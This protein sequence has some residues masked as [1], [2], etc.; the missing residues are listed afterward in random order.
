MTARELPD[1]AAA[2][3]W[4]APDAPVRLQILG[5]LRVWREGVELAPGSRQQSAVLALLLAREG[6]PV[7]TDE[8]IGLLWGEDA[9]ASA[10]NVIHQYIGSL[11]RLLEPGLRARQT[12]S[13]LLRRGNGY[14]CA[15]GP[16]A[17]DLAMF[18]A[19]MSRAQAFVERGEDTA[20]L[21]HLVDAL[22]LWS[23]PAGDG[24]DPGATA[25]ATFAALN[26]SFFEAVVTAT[27]IAVGVGRPEVV[28]PSLRLAAA[29][30]PF[31]EPVQAGLVTAL[32]AAG[33]QAEALEVFRTVRA[34]LGA[35][36]GIEPGHLLD[37]AQRRVLTQN[38]PAPALRVV[39][40]PA[41]PGSGERGALVV[42][43]AEE[44]AL[45]RAAIA[46]THA[47]E[48]AAV[49][50]EGEPGAGKTCLLDEV[51][52][53]AAARGALV[54]WG[55][56]L[57]GDGTPSL[58]PWTQVAG[59]AL[60]RLP[61]PDR[62]HWLSGELSI[63]LTPP[64]ETAAGQITPDTTAQ[65][66]LFE[67]VVGLLESL[68]AQQP[69][70]LV[71][72]DLQW[73][74][75]ASL[76]L[77]AHV[78]A[79]APRGVVLLTALRERASTAN[80]EL[81]KT[82][83]A[84]GR[85]PGHRRL[86]LGPLAFDDVAELLRRETGRQPSAG[87]TRS[88]LA[89]TDGNPFFV[90][91]LSRVLPA[92]GS[93][94]DAAV[95]TTI[96]DLVLTLVSALDDATAR[97]VHIAA[98]VGRQIDL[99]LLARAAGLEVQTCLDQLDAAAVQGLI[100]LS[101]DDPF[102]VRF[103]H[104]VVREAVSTAITAER[105]LDLHRRIADALD[106]DG[107]PEDPV[108][109]QFAHHLWSAGPLVDPAR[110]IDALIRA[111]RCAAAKTAL[112]T[113]E[114]YLRSAVQTARA[115][116]DSGLEFDALSELITVLGMS[117]PHDIAVM[118]FQERA[119][120]LARSAGRDEDAAVLL[121]SRWMALAYAA[122]YDR[123][124][125]LA[126]RLLTQGEASS[127]PVVR[128]LG[129]QAWGL[130]QVSVG[131]IGEAYRHLSAA[132]T[133]LVIVPAQR[134]GDVVWYA[135][136]LSALGLL[137]ETTALH[138]D[139]GQA[140]TLLRELEVLAGDDPFKITV[141]AVHSVRIASVAGDADWALRATEKGLAADPELS[142][143]FF[144]MYQRLARHWALAVTGRDPSGSA[145]EVRRLITENLLDPPR[146]DIATWYGLLAEMHLAAGELEH[147]MNALEL[148]D[149]ALD[150]YGQRYSEGLILLMRARLLAAQGRP[151]ATVTAAAEAAR[152][153]SI[154]REAHL[155]ARR[156]EDFLAHQR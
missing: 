113:A 131:N 139:V 101:S 71:L 104:D 99:R 102:S 19:R 122:Q 86:T 64:G 105:T 69:V 7:S 132:S 123:S 89:R 17:L 96:R 151:S 57:D 58:W 36:L 30:A 135:Q 109:E 16:D 121:Y 137:A 85:V 94:D 140:Q 145:R 50:V 15:A 142:F 107:A 31:H 6:R 13:Y 14:L 124:A 55:Q 130:Q 33:Q 93:L 156:A 37:D 38:L 90:Q 3:P 42:G 29:I 62:D 88:V 80:A 103:T 141:W 8:L 112:D 53:E 82:L 150:A 78:A 20:A 1:G 68:A 18:R 52:T 146:S 44:L 5:P 116:H 136:Q 9:P 66:R 67:A 92:G 25:Q 106:V 35:E 72:D 100:E 81:T 127:I 129:Q 61:D 45:L 143:G 10:V 120:S 39:R 51:T 95:P 49:I 83:T 70:V 153:L 56:C 128:A 24:I 28:L 133:E 12:G 144:G 115:A 76:R 2:L 98:L 47:G 40:D 110:T 87:V 60:S 74:D 54:I 79:R 63:L 32:G 114:R 41:P 22:T 4:P 48:P 134:S 154:V 125:I 155:F 77:L 91:E 117:A 26:E 126:R 73:A 75:V 34:R 119:E 11:R 97:L 108:I 149:R 46:R 152:E 59:T 138:G 118:Q 23:G 84:L 65:F 27:D 43:R 148:A 147:A 21:E 111:G